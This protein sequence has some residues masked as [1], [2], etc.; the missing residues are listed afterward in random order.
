MMKIKKKYCGR[1]VEFKCIRCGGTGILSGD[2]ICTYCNGT[3]YYTR[4]V[5]D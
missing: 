3:G 2:S 4:E 5:D 1:E